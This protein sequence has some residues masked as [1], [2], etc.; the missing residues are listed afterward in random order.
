MGIMSGFKRAVG[1][2]SGDVETPAELKARLSASKEPKDQFAI[3][4]AERLSG[5]NQDPLARAL[6][7]MEQNGTRWS[8]DPDRRWADIAR[9]AHGIAE[10]AFKQTVEGMDASLSKAVTSA[11]LVD[12]AR[13]YGGRG[14]VARHVGEATRDLGERVGSMLADGAAPENLAMQNTRFMGGRRN[15]GLETRMA[16][17]TKEHVREPHELNREQHVQWLLDT[18]RTFIAMAR[19]GMLPDDAVVSY[20][21]DIAAYNAPFKPEQGRMDRSASQGLDTPEARRAVVGREVQKSMDAVDASAGRSVSPAFR[22][23]P[24]KAIATNQEIEAAR[25]ADLS[26]LPDAEWMATGNR[27]ITNRMEGMLVGER[28]GYELRDAIEGR[29][30]QGDEWKARNGPMIPPELLKSAPPSDLEAARSGRIDQ[31]GGE[32]LRLTMMEVKRDSRQLYHATN[33]NYTHHAKH[34]AGVEQAA[35]IAASQAPAR[36]SVVKMQTGTGAARGA[37]AAAAAGRMHG[38]M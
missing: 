19:T 15:L 6:P 9:T 1:I 13:S 5:Y 34:T 20:A 37:M 17:S 32:A 24:M 8:K 12:A 10:T 14:P 2:D 11:S 4:L 23:V 18:N 26:K 7:E 35:K 16:E 28:A 30:R 22:P 21:R 3:A 25:V 27:R 36:D 38:G 31:I 29:A 33:H